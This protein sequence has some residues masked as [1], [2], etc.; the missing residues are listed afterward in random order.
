MRSVERGIAGGGIIK[1][2]NPRFSDWEGMVA[3]R[4]AWSS[5]RMG[6]SW[7]GAEQCSALRGRR[8]RLIK[9][10]RR[11]IIKLSN[12]RLS[13]RES[14]YPVTA[15]DRNFRGRGL[16]GLMM[17]QARD[18]ARGTLRGGESPEEVSCHLAP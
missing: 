2:S 12:R 17:L 16:D 3:D 8:S 7:L 5:G 9:V 1:L 15:W 14:S 6:C 11:G 4:L 13:D 18:S 10:R